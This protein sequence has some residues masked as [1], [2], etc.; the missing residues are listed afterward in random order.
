MEQS[1]IR[2]SCHVERSRIALRSM[3]ATVTTVG[4]LPAQQ[5]RAKTIAAPRRVQDAREARRLGRLDPQQHEGRAVALAD[6]ARTGG[7][8]GLPLDRAGELDA[9]ARCDLLQVDPQTRVALL[10]AGL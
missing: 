6:E 3:R 1:E 8:V 7:D 4:P 9:G 10:I 2:D 5:R